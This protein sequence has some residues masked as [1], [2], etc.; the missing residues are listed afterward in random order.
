MEFNEMKMIWDSQTQEPLYAMNESALHRI[1]QHRV[2]AW[3]RS[4]SRCFAM[5]ITVGLVCGAFMLVGASTL[6]FGSPT[7]LAKL[8]WIKVTV[9]NWDV[10]ALFLAAGIWFYYCAYMNLARTRQQ[11]R[12]EAFDSSL[13]GDIDRALAQTDFQVATARNIVWWGLIPA[14]LAAALWVVTLF[15]LE[16]APAWAYVLLGSIALCAFVVVVTGKQRS[17]TNEFQPR[18]RELESLRTKLVEPQA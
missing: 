1:V 14:W 11:R 8:P 17:I 13:R 4:M 7:W 18:R 16:A 10:A 9:S 15:H 2:Q 6:A 5:E 3:E 12:L